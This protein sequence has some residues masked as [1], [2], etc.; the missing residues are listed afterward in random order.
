[1]VALVQRPLIALSL[2]AFSTLGAA[3]ATE[4]DSGGGV[5]Q[6][7]V[8][9]DPAGD[10]F[11]LIESPVAT[12]LGDQSQYVDVRSLAFGG[13]RAGSYEIRVQFEGRPDPQT[14]ASEAAAIIDFRCFIFWKFNDAKNIYYRLNLGANNIL[15]PGGTP[16]NLFAFVWGFHETPGVTRVNNNPEVLPVSWDAAANTFVVTV[17]KAL[18]L[19]SPNNFPARGDTL[20]L[21]RG[22]C[23]SEHLLLTYTVRDSIR[24]TAAVY[25][26]REPGNG[27]QVYIHLGPLLA[28]DRLEKVGKIKGFTPTLAPLGI[29]P[30]Q[31]NTVPFTLKNHATAATDVNLR[32][33]VRDPNGTGVGWPVGAPPGLHLEGGQEA[34][35]ALRFVPPADANTGREYLLTVDVSGSD[36]ALLSRANR[37]IRLVGELSTEANILN[38]F[39]RPGLRSDLEERYVGDA[40]PEWELK[41][42]SSKQVEGWGTQSVR[43]SLGR[44]TCSSFKSDPLPKSVRLDPTG[45]AQLQLQ[46]NSP[47]VKE[48]HGEFEFY[49]ENQ[50][51]LKWSGNF[52]TNAPY[53]VTSKA[54][55]YLTIEAGT[56]LRGFLCFGLQLEQE[57]YGRSEIS[58]QTAES[59]LRLPILPEPLEETTVAI[60]PPGKLPAPGFWIVL[61][62]LAWAA[63]RMRRR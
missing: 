55:A 22:D 13:E 7:L 37:P 20:S 62:G 15:S 3:S 61:L 10:P 32:A 38:F 42:S 44:T 26:F 16:E 47:D 6:D 52:P 19:P 53:V 34:E 31:E 2:V 50:S 28:G 46:A 57:G 18:T 49:G 56:I 30:G 40:V 63:G 33:I 36:D 1:M 24:P 17:P 14:M 41:L 59:F 12:P 43:H 58:F 21:I 27:D 39:T 29:V 9:P 11:L 35:L 8:I 5:G 48:I 4:Q 51:W 25:K 45:E 60:P 23:G 54:P